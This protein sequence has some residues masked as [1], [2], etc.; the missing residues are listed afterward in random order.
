MPPRV[1]GAFPTQAEAWAKKKAMKSAMQSEL[2]RWL[3]L[4]AKAKES[5]RV[6]AAAANLAESTFV[7]VR[8]LCW[9]GRARAVGGYC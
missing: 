6:T 1:H 5:A 4:G 7:E 2:R 8:A 9:S 3:Q